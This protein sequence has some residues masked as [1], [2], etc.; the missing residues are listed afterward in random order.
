[1]TATNIW[2]KVVSFHDPIHPQHR[3][4]NWEILMCQRRRK[5]LYEKFY[6]AV[7]GLC[8]LSFCEISLVGMPNNSLQEFGKKIGFGRF[9]MKIFS[10]S[11]LSCFP[12][13]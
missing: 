3:P 6:D 11:D 9:F 10:S 4:N 12:F 2:E 5:M 1:M 13:F 8:L 7:K